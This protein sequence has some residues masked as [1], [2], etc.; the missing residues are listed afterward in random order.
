MH[1]KYFL[2]GLLFLYVPA[3]AAQ[4]TGS[5]SAAQ[6]G[7]A[8]ERSGKIGDPWE[9]YQAG[10]WNEALQA[11]VDLQVERP[12]DPELM[13][14]VGSSQYQ[15][16][17]YDAAATSFGRAA[18]LADDDLRAKALYNMGNVSYR[19][20]KLKEA[21]D[22]YKAALEGNPDDQDAKYNLEFVRDEIRRR[23]EEAQKRQQEQ[24]DQQQDQ[25][26]DQQESRQQD[27]QDRGGSQQQEQAGQDSDGDGLPDELE[28]NAQNPTD[29]ANPDSDGDGLADGEE[30]RNANGTVDQGETDPN[31]VDS[32]GD[33]VPDSA[34]DTAQQ[35]QQEATELS[36]EEAERY[37]QA[38]Q[39][40][41]PDALPAGAVR[42]R[43]TGKDW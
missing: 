22:Y 40:Q 27:Q 34:Q 1:R 25:Q 28:R 16:G 2:L 21:I 24:K 17:D 38:L 6:T 30:D 36:P 12:N 11:F 41:R 8:A 26:Q 37:L 9:A 20:G 33:G 10:R 32:D 29:P 15:M 23:H 5:A 42:G 18:T 14:D 35:Q 39:E 7:Q 43:S 13:M 19:Q 3:S 31:K 4:D